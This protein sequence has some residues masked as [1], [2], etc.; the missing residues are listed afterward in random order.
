MIRL[1]TY[2]GGDGKQRGYGQCYSVD[3]VNPIHDKIKHQFEIL[4]TQ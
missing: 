3:L 2:E 1:H 4:L